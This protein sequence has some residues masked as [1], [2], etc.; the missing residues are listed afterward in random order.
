MS[1]KYAIFTMD[2]ESFSDTGCVHDSGIPVDVSMM[3]G[4]DEYLSILESHNIKST[5]FVV[6]DSIRHIKDKIKGYIEKGHKI[7]LHG[8]DHSSPVR[9]SAE[10]FRKSTMFAKELL[11]R[12]YNIRIKGFRAPFFGMDNDRLQVL[13]DLG[14][15]YDSSRLDFEAARYSGMLDMKDFKKVDKHV[16]CKDGFC[17]FGIPKHRYCGVNMPVGG[18]GYIRL[19]FWPFIRD[20]LISYLRRSNY[21]VFYL[22]PFELSKEKMPRIPHLKSYDQYYLSHGLRD[23]G[24][25][26]ERIIKMLKK[27]SFE[28]IT[29]EEYTDIL[30]KK[31][32]SK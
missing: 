12:D 1:K 22:H 3:D 9:M 26:I 23:Y 7:A 29:F 18:G 5:L 30:N 27:R 14:F 21:Y 15:A 32:N 31:Y 6:Y 4:I 24:I 13:M 16:Y 2:V 19:G 28:F 10:D 25:K 20:F 17:E 8:Y 11:E